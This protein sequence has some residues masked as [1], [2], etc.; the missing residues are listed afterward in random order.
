MHTRSKLINTSQI[1]NRSEAYINTVTD[2]LY[3]IKGGSRNL[4]WGESNQGPQS[5][6]KGE[7]RIEGAKR[8]SIEGEAR[9]LRAK[10]EPRAKP[11]KKRGGGGGGGS[12][13]GVRWA[14]FQKRLKN[15]TWS[16]NHSFWCIFEALFDMTNEMV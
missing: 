10:P 11:E 14:P 4:F 1:R 3:T 13:E 9:E 15:Q 12:G 6:V 7:A 16:W 5:K 8:P 2:M